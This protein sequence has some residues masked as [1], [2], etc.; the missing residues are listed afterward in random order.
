MNCRFELVYQLT[1][2]SEAAENRENLIEMA[3]AHV[4]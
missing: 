4:Y 3:G 1:V 2:C